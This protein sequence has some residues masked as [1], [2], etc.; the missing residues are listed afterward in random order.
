MN[1]DDNDERN[2]CVPDGRPRRINHIEIFHEVV[3]SFKGRPW[4]WKWNWFGEAIDPDP[5]KMKQSTE[6]EFEE[7]E[8]E[9]KS[10]KESSKRV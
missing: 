4:I 1:G 8:G 5:W 6:S 10:Q 7:E 3:L 9:E 2:G